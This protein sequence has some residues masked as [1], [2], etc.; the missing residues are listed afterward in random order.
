MGRMDFRAKSGKGV[1]SKE[2]QWKHHKFFL[3]KEDRTA[4]VLDSF[5]QHRIYMGKKDKLNEDPS[6]AV[7]FPSSLTGSLRFGTISPPSP[8]LRLD[9]HY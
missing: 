4:A 2:H 3:L 6:A 8:S 7:K 1:K 9:H 5:L